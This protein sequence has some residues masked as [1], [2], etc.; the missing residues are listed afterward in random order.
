MSRRQL[1]GSAAGIVAML[2]RQ[3]E[4]VLI[5][6]IAGLESY[7]RFGYSLKERQS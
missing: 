5:A 6:P 4:G 2:S 1:M 3:F 7:A